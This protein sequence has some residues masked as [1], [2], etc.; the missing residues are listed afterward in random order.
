MRTLLRP[1]LSLLMIMPVNP[2]IHAETLQSYVREINANKVDIED[3]LSD[4]VQY[5]DNTNRV[6]V[7]AVE[8]ERE[9]WQ[10]DFG[11]ISPDLP[12]HTPEKENRKAP[13]RMQE[14]GIKR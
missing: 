3:Q 4:K 2:N 13:A 12:S 10:K 6:L 8:M 1:Y 5:Y 14:K 7:N 11:E 9:E